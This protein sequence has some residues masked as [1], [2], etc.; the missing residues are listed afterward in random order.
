LGNELYERVGNVL[1]N[2]DK[3][4]RGLETATR[5]F[6]KLIGSVDG[7]L[8]PTMRRFPDLGVGSEELVAPAEVE[9]QPRGLRA[10]ELPVAD[11]PLPPEDSEG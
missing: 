4:G 1:E 10:A 6:N 2:V 5:A 8:L 9:L 11:E 3:T 7:R